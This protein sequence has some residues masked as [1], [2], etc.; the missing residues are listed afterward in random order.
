MKKT[1]F[2][3]ILLVL[4][5][6]STWAQDHVTRF[7]DIPVDG[8][9]EEMIEKLK[10]KGFTEAHDEYQQLLGK[11]DD[12]YVVITIYTHNDK[13]YRV[14]VFFRIPVSEIDAKADFN[15]LIKAF[16]NNDDYLPYTST[17]PKFEVS[18]DEN[19]TKDLY[20]AVFLQLPPNISFSAIRAETNALLK[21]KF[22]EI[23]LTNPT[24]QEWEDMTNLVMQKITAKHMDRIINIFSTKSN[25][26]PGYYHTAIIY[27]NIRNAPADVKQQKNI[28]IHP[29]T[30]D[31]FINP[32]KTTESSATQSS[33]AA[34]K[35]V[36][37]FLGIPVDGKKSEVSAKLQIKGLTPVYHNPAIKERLI[38]K[39]LCTNTTDTSATNTSII[40]TTILSGKMDNEDKIIQIMEY[41]D[42]VYR[43]IISDENPS[44]ET[45]IKAKFNKL[46]RRLLASEDYIPYT[47]T[48][49]DFEIPENEKL[50]LAQKRYTVTFFQLPPGITHTMVHQEVDTGIEEIYK[51][52]RSLKLT[53]SEGEAMIDNFIKATVEKHQQRRLWFLITSVREGEFRLVIFYDNVYNLPEGKDL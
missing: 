22:S 48:F 52:A 2:I 8:T 41:N 34:P 26:I 51:K 10:A 37:H 23:Q 47:G 45:S 11:F 1:L 31:L 18:M 43:I 5:S 21:S 36:I 30:M 6:I 40:D 39:G 12:N 14:T 29:Y 20:C 24:I 9:K 17:E 50:A 15:Y 35:N 38:S 53:T 49:P 13:V 27:D 3:I 7:L 32:S 19:Y 46:C 33:L 16:M 42:K 4:Y 28:I 25:K 44:D